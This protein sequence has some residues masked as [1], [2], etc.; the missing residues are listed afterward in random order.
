MCL[1]WIFGQIRL[2]YCSLHP[3]HLFYY[4]YCWF[5]SVS[6]HPPWL[7][8]RVCVPST[9][10][11]KTTRIR[12][13]LEMLNNAEPSTQN[14]RENSLKMCETA[15]FW[16]FFWSFC[17]WTEWRKINHATF[18]QTGIPGTSCYRYGMV[19]VVNR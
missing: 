16:R 10:T 9:G 17:W 8:F 3:F 4:H 5:S 18:T 7:I 15:F 2:R 1:H 19:I 14:C 11:N 13:H 12:D 6:S